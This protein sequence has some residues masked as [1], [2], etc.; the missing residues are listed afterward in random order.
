MCNGDM[1]LYRVIPW[2]YPTIPGQS[3]GGTSVDPIPPPTPSPV[4]YDF[5]G[6]DVSFKRGTDQ[7]ASTG[8]N[9]SKNQPNADFNIAVSG[10]VSIDTSAVSSIK[11]LVV[12]YD[13]EPTVKTGDGL[14]FDRISVW[15]RGYSGTVDFNKDPVVTVGVLYLPEKTV[16][17]FASFST[18]LSGFMKV[19]LQAFGSDGQLL[20]ESQEI[21][22]TP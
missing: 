2:S 19:K 6:A 20:E 11:I 10:V 15:N 3:S 18:G 12:E 7:V 8:L 1:S 4:Y 14:T 22:V 5:S 21:T 13:F 17:W 9:G 16:P